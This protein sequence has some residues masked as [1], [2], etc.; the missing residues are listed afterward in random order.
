MQKIHLIPDLKK[1]SDGF[2][3]EPVH[4]FFLYYSLFIIYCI[5][6]GDHRE[7]R[8]CQLPRRREDAAATNP[9]DKEM[10]D[11]LVESY[12]GKHQAK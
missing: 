9:A 1:D 7:K 11:A 5:F 6:V 3:G 4:W 2:F 12:P 8:P 10:I